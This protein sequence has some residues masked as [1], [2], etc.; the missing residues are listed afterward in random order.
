MIWIIGGTSESRELLS[1]IKDS[2]NYIVTVATEEGLDFF[3]SDKV[4]MGR[5][6]KNEMMGFIDQYHIDTVVDL[7]H[8]YATIVTDNARS[9]CKEKGIQYLRYVRDRIQLADNEIYLNSYE[10]CYEYLKGISGTVFFTTG[11]KNI[12]DFQK[13]REKNR[14]IYRILPALESLEIC[15]ENNI[16]MKDIVAILGPFSKEMNKVMFMDYDVDYCVMKDSGNIGGTV[17]KIQACRELEVTPIII[18]RKQEEGITQ[19]D[20]IIKA[21]GTVRDQ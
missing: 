18:G 19:L 12:C 7:S 9:V 20:D 5:L 21:L 17:E 11:S 16:H 2:N 4:I 15:R 13:V 3:D 6:N 10:E 1:K 8:P 14:F